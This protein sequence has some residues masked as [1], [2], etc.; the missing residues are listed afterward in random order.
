[1]YVTDATATTRLSTVAG[2]GKMQVVARFPTGAVQVIATE[3]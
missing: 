3:P 2:G 1:M